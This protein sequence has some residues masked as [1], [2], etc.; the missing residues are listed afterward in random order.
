MISRIE[1]LADKKSAGTFARYSLKYSRWV[2]FKLRSRYLVKRSVEW[3]VGKVDNVKLN[4]IWLCDIDMILVVESLLKK[5]RFNV[6][7][8]SQLA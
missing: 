8:E 5:F 3:D 7:W 1:V 6:I 2:H 4:N